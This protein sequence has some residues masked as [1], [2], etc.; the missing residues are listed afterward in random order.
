MWDFLQNQLSSNKIFLIMSITIIIPVIPLLF[1]EIRRIIKIALLLSK[2]LFK[3]NKYKKIVDYGSLNEFLENGGYSYDIE[4]D[5]FYSN[6]DAWQRD[7]GYCRLYD[8]LAAPFS[9]IIDCEPIYFEYNNKKWLIEFWKGQ[10]GMTTGCEVGVYVSDGPDIEAIEFSGAFYKCVRDEDMLDMSFELKKNGKTLMVRNQKH[11][12]LTGFKL[13]EFSEP[14][15]LTVTFNIKLKDEI[16]RD[17][18]VK[19][20]KNSG[21]L[22]QNLKIT[23]NNIELFF[24]QPH[25][26]QPLSRIKKSDRLTQAKNKL[27]CDKFQEMTSEYDN[28][29][30]KI[31]AIQKLDPR[32]MKKIL[33]IGKSSS[34]FEGY[35]KIENYLS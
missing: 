30:D 25:M 18:F 29:L 4:Q 23:G 19:G 10:Y 14:E 20:L 12:W 32:M 31:I 17:E 8:E 33:M 9:M 7:M 15:E 2:R 16:M 27:L 13:G 35:R 11:W 5:I 21:Y 28:S 24:Y 1:P 22:E 34:L 3:S 26:P 6:I